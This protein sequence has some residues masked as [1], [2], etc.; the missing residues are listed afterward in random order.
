MAN[1][2]VITTSDRKS[3]ED[4]SEAFEYLEQNPKVSII[5]SIVHDGYDPEA[6]DTL[7]LTR[8]TKIDEPR[9]K[10]KN[11]RLLGLHKGSPVIEKGRYI[12]RTYYEDEAETIEVVIESYIDVFENGSLVRVDCQIDWIN[13]DGSVGMTRL[14]KKKK[15]KYQA[16]KILKAR[17]EAQIDYLIEGAKGTPAEPLVTGIFEHYS[18]QINEYEKVVNSVLADA[19]NAETDPTISAYLNTVIDPETGATIKASI[20]NQIT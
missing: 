14:I 6:P 12:S 11:Y 7:R 15:S 8:I 2:T 1:K 18:K 9:L 3:F 13:N 16:G 4:I 17:R 10:Y 5:E 20:L 19:I